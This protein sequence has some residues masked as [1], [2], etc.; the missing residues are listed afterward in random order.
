MKNI[1]P[2]FF[3]FLSQLTIA[4]VN[5]VMPSEA[6]T[7]YQNAMLTIKPEIKNIIEK[8]ATQQPPSKK[9]G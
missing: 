6:N 9:V 3:L 2:L 5:A 8:N 7:F 1:L 4:Q